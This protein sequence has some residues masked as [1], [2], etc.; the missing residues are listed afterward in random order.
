VASV[1][2]EDQSPIMRRAKIRLAV[3]VVL[4]CVAIGSLLKISNDKNIGPD[5]RITSAVPTNPTTPVTKAPE[6]AHEEIEAK[7]PVAPPDPVYQSFTADPAHVA[8]LPENPATLVPTAT[9][10]ATE[11]QST[12]DTPEA[13]VSNKEKTEADKGNIRVSTSG[14]FILQAG[15]F[16]DMNNARKQIDKLAAH[17]L[18]AFT[19]TRL[20]IGPFSS[21]QEVG[22]ARETIQSSG[23]N[24]PLQDG[25]ISSAKGL[26]MLGG[27]HS[28][29]GHADTLRDGLVEKGLSTRTETR[30]LIGPF[31]T[32]EQADRIRN[33]IKNH[34][35]SV[36]LMR[37]GN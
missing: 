32:K 2:I 13:K 10:D 36:V 9:R 20:W 33:R 19:E 14:T 24:I 21:E 25:A 16:S 22:S 8:E 26:M 3:A 18:P 30:V 6:P 7:P 1:I 11:N 34:N 37:T 29:M 5:T 15:V 23:L 35:I 31:E 27:T 28:D 12:K 4:L 17:D